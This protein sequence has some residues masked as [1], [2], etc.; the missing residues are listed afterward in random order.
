MAKLGR[1]SRSRPPLPAL[2]PVS[3]EV[4]VCPEVWVEAKEVEWDVEWAAEAAAADGW[5]D[6]DWAPAAP[7]F[8]L[9]AA[10]PFRTREASPVPT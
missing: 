5:E 2:G 1:R 7:A 4:K 3:K 9:S 10:P 8:V 6:L